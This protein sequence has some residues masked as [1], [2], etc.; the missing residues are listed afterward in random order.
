MTP[1]PQACAMPA[2]LNGRKQYDFVARMF[3]AMSNNEFVRKAIFPPHL[4]MAVFPLMVVNLLSI[5]F[6]FKNTTILT[7]PI[8]IPGENKSL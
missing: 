4:G 8:F 5:S 3:C 1:S 2:E 7:W 6:T